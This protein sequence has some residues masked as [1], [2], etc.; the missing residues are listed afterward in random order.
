MKKDSIVD[1]RE[2]LEPI[3]D[4]ML[5]AGM[6]AVAVEMFRIFARFHNQIHNHD[7]HPGEYIFS[8]DSDEYGTFYWERPYKD[9]YLDGYICGAVQMIRLL[10]MYKDSFMNL[11]AQIPDRVP[12]QK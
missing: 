8:E 10:T 6:P 5:L 3:L 7:K 1:A 4:T 12:R 2:G 11:L 9:D